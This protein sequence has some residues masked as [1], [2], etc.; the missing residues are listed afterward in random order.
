MAEKLPKAMPI[1]Q[2]RSTG[3]RRRETQFPSPQWS[4]ARVLSVPLG[5]SPGTAIPVIVHRDF[6]SE[7]K[8]LVCSVCVHTAC[9]PANYLMWSLSNGRNGPL[10]SASPENLLQMRILRPPTRYAGEIWVWGPAVR[11]F[12]GPPADDPVTH[13]HE[14]TCDL[15]IDLHGR[16]SLISLKF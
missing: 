7:H 2:S 4:I 3:P 14:Q 10:T 11:V 1:T 15:I 6:L 5:S 13:E 12:T 16:K 9:L 8:S